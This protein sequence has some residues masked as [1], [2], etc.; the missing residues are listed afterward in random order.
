MLAN[1]LSKNAS[2]IALQNLL[3][4]T[5]S[6]IFSSTFADLLSNTSPVIGCRFG[7]ISTQGA[8]SRRNVA[9]RA[10]ISLCLIITKPPLLQLKAWP[11]SLFL[12]HAHMLGIASGFHPYR[13]ARASR[14]ALLWRANP[15]S[16][17]N[18]VSCSHAH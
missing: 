14:K 4:F 12:P 8:T 15:C 3:H 16:C 17:S 11:T 2:C 7:S 6:L 10:L 5:S 13:R 18:V 9:V 1:L